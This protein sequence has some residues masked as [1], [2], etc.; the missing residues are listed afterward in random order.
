[1]RRS[2]HLARVRKWRQS[3][4]LSSDQGRVA[5][6]GAKLSSEQTT[7]L[8]HGSTH[9]S[10]SIMYS[11]IFRRWENPCLQHAKWSS[12]VARNCH[13][14]KRTTVL[15]NAGGQWS[16]VEE[17]CWSSSEDH[18]QSTKRGRGCCSR[19][20]FVSSSLLHEGPGSPL[21]IVNV[22]LLMANNRTLPNLYAFE[23][24][25]ATDNVASPIPP[26][27]C[28]PH[29]PQTSWTISWAILVKFGEGEEM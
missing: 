19:H 25:S 8:H 15:P 14:A 11:E 17:A 10:Q 22:P 28:Y 9:C 23:E 26:P 1:M 29:H 18:W 27:R 21:P 7:S 12:L 2:Q 13:W 24:S 6:C 3:H 20:D 5:T 16:G 4:V